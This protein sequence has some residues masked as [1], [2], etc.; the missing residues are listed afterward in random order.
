MNRRKFLAGLL[1]TAAIPAFAVASREPCNRSDVPDAEPIKRFY[2]N[3]VTRT[4]PP[5]F[6]DEFMEEWSQ[7]TV[8][9]LI[10]GTDL[11]PTQFTGFTPAWSA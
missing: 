5:P 7:Q 8:S 9:T 4:E 3:R 11:A 6:D 2:V 10:Y 1:A